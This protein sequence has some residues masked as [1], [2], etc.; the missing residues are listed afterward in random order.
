MVFLRLRFYT[1]GSFLQVVSDF[2]GF[3]KSS[4]S[5]I[6][7]KVSRTLAS[8]HSNLLRFQRSNKMSNCLHFL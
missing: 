3:S 5:Q 7:R 4:A 1:T 6:V 2:V 8:F